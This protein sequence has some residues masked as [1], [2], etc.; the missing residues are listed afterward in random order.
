MNFSSEYIYNLISK[1][2]KIG[3]N[4]FLD[5][6]VL[7]YTL[8]SEAR[9]PENFLHEIKEAKQHITLLL[10][11]FNEQ[12][13]VTARVPHLSI[14]VVQERPAKVPLSFS[15]ERLWFIDRLQGSTNYHIS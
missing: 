6:G 11:N 3:L 14:P 2:R 7:R 5:N 9:I 1:A 15:Q 12:N 10:E 13:Y 8:I 4:L